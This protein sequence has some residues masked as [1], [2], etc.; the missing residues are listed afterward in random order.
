MIEPEVLHAQRAFA[1]AQQLLA[2]VPVRQLAQRE[3]GWY[4]TETHA[5][6]G[7]FALVRDGVGLDDL[8]GEVL[9]V[10]AGGR[11]VFVYVMGARGIPVDIALARRAFLAIGRLSR[12][13]IRAVVEVVA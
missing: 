8:I 6:Q 13:S 7:A 10:R 2:G 9:R 12:E 5:T 3:V 4:G 1:T 11:E